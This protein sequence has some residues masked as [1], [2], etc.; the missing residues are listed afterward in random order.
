MINNGVLTD[1]NAVSNN[2]GLDDTVLLY[3]D[4]IVDPDLLICEL[5]RLLLMNG[6]FDDT[7]FFDDTGTADVDL[8]QV[9]SED[10]F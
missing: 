3:H 5:L 9:A 2:S 7:A 6:R 4:M 1:K 8:T 10:Y